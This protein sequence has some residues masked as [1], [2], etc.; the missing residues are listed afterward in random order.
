MATEHDVRAKL[1]LDTRQA[2]QATARIEGKLAGLASTIKGSN[3]MAFQL[4]R[5]L[6]A[7]G[8]AYVGVNAVTSAFSSLL[9]TT[10]DYT[11][12]LEKTRIGL[13]TV[14]QAVDGT[15]W[16]TAE[17]ASSQVFENLRQMS[18]TSPAGPAE[19][20]EIFQGIVGPIRNAGTE[21]ARI[22]KITANTVLAA[23]A[24]DVDLEQARRDI[25]MMARGA[26]G[27]DVKLFSMLRSMGLIKEETEAWNKSLTAQERVE[28][29]EEALSKF[30]S[31]GAKFA[32]TWAGSRQVFSGLAKELG[33]IAMTPVLTMLADRLTKLNQHL[34]ENREKYEAMAQTFGTRVAAR[35][36]SALDVGVRA[37]Q[38]VTQNWGEISAR[39]ERTAATVKELAPTLA[40][41]AAVYAVGRPV[42]GGALQGGAMALG[43][44]GGL[45]NLAGMLGIGAGG[46]AG[47]GAAAAAGGAGA[48][49]AGAAGAAAA[50]PI[51]IALAV[52]AGAVVAASGAVMVAKRHW[53]ELSAFFHEDFVLLKLALQELWE[54]AWP[55]LINVLEVV[56]YVTLAVVIPAL[57]FM[58][59]WYRKIA[60]GI[61]MA[62]E[63]FNA[64][65]AFMRENVIWVINRASEELDGLYSHINSVVEAF[66]SMTDGLF[67]LGNA[68]SH[69]VRTLKM[70]SEALGLGATDVAD[71]R[72]APLDVSS[73]HLIGGLAT[74]NRALKQ[75]EAENKTQRRRGGVPAGRGGTQINVQKMVIQQQFKEKDPDRIL[76]VMMD[77]INRQAESRVSSRF[78][79]AFA[80]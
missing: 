74:A 58:L 14:L 53:T 16:A 49:G 1:T 38:W 22:E 25:T 73:T 13:T 6:L 54:Q 78:T 64:F 72:P 32:R 10:T 31:S 71:V 37:F 39:I 20:F 30:E 24:L 68:V 79:P 76:H 46:A 63:A 23:S 36:E 65:Y 52:I 70:G 56:G 57:K 29:L 9:R 3:N 59:W 48:A 61:T 77:D 66:A 7:M 27:M 44:A 40:K 28:R 69:F 19:M 2:Q 41:V 35:L 55:A 21:M 33:R 47:G 43:A 12:Q 50:A 17:Q 51:A 34:T 15:D 11:S 45:A 80:R 18:L 42:V 67:G 4:T 75:L 8:A 62:L 5:N 26:A 60:E